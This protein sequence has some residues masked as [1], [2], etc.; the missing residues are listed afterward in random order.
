MATKRDYYEILGVP[1][2]ATQEEIKKAY[3]KLARKYH[4]DICKKPEC[5]EKFKEINEA[6]QVLSDPEKRKLYDMYGH[7]AFEGAPPSEG[8]FSGQSFG[9][10]EEIFKTFEDIF[11]GKGGFF[12]RIFEEAA[13]GGRR[14]SR[15]SSAPQKG[16]DIYHTVTISLE[17]AFRGAVITV[18]VTRRVKCPVCGG[19]GAIR[20][21]TCPRCGGKGSVVF[22]PNPF[23][24]IE[25][26][27]PTCGGRGVIAEPCP[28]CGGEGFVYKREEIKVKIPPGVDNGTKL[29]VD[30]KG[31]EGRFG[32]PPGDLYI[33]T[34]VEPHPVFERRGD[35]LYVDVRITYP[36]AVLG[37]EVEVPTIEG[38]KVKVK[39][40]EGTKEGDTVRVEGKGMP[41]LRGG[42]R[43]DMVVR[44]HIDVPSFGL[45]AKLTGKEKRIKQLL[46]ELQREL[47]KPER[48]IK[49]KR[50]G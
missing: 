2:N 37:G 32:G 33:I 36:E 16:E 24:V 30:G 11:G 4:P 31:H 44:F 39:I 50:E 48:V 14:R 26:I 45:L 27:C 46:E 21:R 22:R 3:R 8:G 10:F 47:P 13:F 15:S 18:P 25:E 34:K 49:H 19:K 23:M 41:R 20:E 7:A 5:E 12:E 42:G 29:K 40:P 35:N 9:G 1:R 17:D 38:E 43:G 28:E 6:Y